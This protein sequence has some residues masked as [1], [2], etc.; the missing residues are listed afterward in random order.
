MIDR[1][2]LINIIDCGHA[3]TK[4][5]KCHTNG[6]TIEFG[7]FQLVHPDASYQCVN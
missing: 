7:E 1:L 5:Q 3:N 2:I 6:H 4:Y